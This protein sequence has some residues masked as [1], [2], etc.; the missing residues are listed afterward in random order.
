MARGVRLPRTTGRPPRFLRTG[1]RRA[2]SLSEAHLQAAQRDARHT[3]R[4]EAQGSIAFVPSGIAGPASAKPTLRV[5]A[6]GDPDVDAALAS[7]VSCSPPPRS[8]TP[9]RPPLPDQRRRAARL[10]RC[11]DCPIPA[12]R[13]SPRTRASVAALLRDRAPMWRESRCSSRANV[14]RPRAC[15]T[16]DPSKHDQILRTHGPCR[17]SLRPRSPGCRLAGR[18][19]HL[20]ADGPWAVPNRPGRQPWRRR[21]L[22]RGK[23][24]LSGRG[25]VSLDC[26]ANRE[27]LSPERAPV[28]VVAALA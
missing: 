10:P 5:L 23:G 7:A 15:R 22:R 24:E 6:E 12:V 3:L 11:P 27:P 19:D 14:K 16:A 20:I 25:D 4:R 9:P 26:L 21:A 1:H 18:S 13:T 17:G 8:L 2:A 28:S